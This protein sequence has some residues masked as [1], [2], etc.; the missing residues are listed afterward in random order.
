MGP[1][2]AR[3]TAQKVRRFLGG[4]F[5][6]GE[7][8]DE[9]ADMVLKSGR[10]PCQDLLYSSRSYSRPYSGLRLS[11]CESAPERLDVARVV[12]DVARACAS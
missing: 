4:F 1:D 2:V 11:V 8:T 5:E 6:K 7:V 3:D 9:N 10:I 12:L